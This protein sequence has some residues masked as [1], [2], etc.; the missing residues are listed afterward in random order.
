M[1]VHFSDVVEPVAADTGALVQG[2]NGRSSGVYRLAGKRLV[3]LSLILIAAPI[4][5]PVIAL[6]ALLVAIDGHSPFFKQVRVG[7]DGRRF[8]MWKLRTM[9][10]DAEEQLAKYLEANPDARSEWENKQKLTHDPRCTRLGRAFRKTSL[11]ELP[12]LLNVVMGDMSLI[13]P[14]PMMP[15]QQSL[16]PGRAY[17]K[18]RPGMTGLWQVSKRNESEFTA[19][20]SFDD[21]YNA[22][23]TLWMDIKILI[24]TAFVVVRGTGV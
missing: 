8:T 10:P 5:V 4:V 19:R 1:T 9:V 2:T 11:D 16:Y 20:A 6:F 14:R 24:K 13:G 22:N 21:A 12:Q 3:D 15:E 23:L 17:Y 7:K 18:L